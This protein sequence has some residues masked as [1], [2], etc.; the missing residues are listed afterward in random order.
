MKNPATIA[1]SLACTLFLTGCNPLGE[2]TVYSVGYYTID[3]TDLDELH[4]QI[5]LHGPKVMGVGNALAA[6]DINMVPSIKYQL[7]DGKCRIT[8]AKVRVNARVT[9]PRHSNEK[10]LKQKLARTWNNLAEYAKVHEAVHLE[11]ADR[12]AVEMEHTISSLEPRK[13]CKSLREIV[14]KVF[15]LM[16]RQHHIEQLKFD[17]D[18]RA[19]IRILASE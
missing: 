14:S 1:M 15:D 5:Q 10:A 8:S 19:R 12:N 11:I 4:Q 6:T 7:R 16:Y 9:L 17:Q 3:G 2:R 13:D 18:E